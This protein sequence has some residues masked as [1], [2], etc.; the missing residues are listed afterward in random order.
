VPS[1]RASYVRRTPSPHA[2]V[3]VIE[4]SRVLEAIKVRANEFLLKPVSQNALREC[5]LAVLTDPRP[6]VHHG[7]YYGPA[8]R[9]VA[10]AAVHEDN[11]QV[12]ANLYMLN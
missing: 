8:P 5:H 2:G 10:A 4:R 7:D 9:K 11:D 1:L 12:I 6:L 3:P